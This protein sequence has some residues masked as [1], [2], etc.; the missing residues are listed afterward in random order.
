M[1]KGKNSERIL[2]KNGSESND[3][4]L[5]GTVIIDIVAFSPTVGQDCRIVLAT[6]F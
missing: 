3:A 5:F 2:S 6:Q 1:T 4:D